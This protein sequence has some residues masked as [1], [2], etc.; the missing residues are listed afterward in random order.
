[1][2]RPLADGI[3]ASSGSIPTLTSLL[4]EESALRLA[5]GPVDDSDQFTYAL[6]RNPS[7]GQTAHPSATSE[8]LINNE[9][10]SS[11]IHL[12]RRIVHQRDP[13]GASS[14]RSP[15]STSLRRR[16]TLRDPYRN[17][18]ADRLGTAT[19]AGGTAIPLNLKLVYCDGGSYNDAHPAKNMLKNDDTVYC[20]RRRNNV[21]VLMQHVSPHN[22]PFELDSLVVKAPRS[23]YSSP[24]TCGLVYVSMHEIRL[25]KKPADRLS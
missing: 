15:A 1:M 8:S 13:D 22:Q 5:I 11:R 16:L 23:G 20:S 18:S 6:Y 7:H 21:N 12:L 3:G 10:I 14:Y 24:V 17:A 25:R 4:N 2:R 9:E 19:I